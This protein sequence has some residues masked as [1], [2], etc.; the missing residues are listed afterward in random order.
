MKWGAVLRSKDYGKTWSRLKPECGCELDDIFMNDVVKT[1]DGTYYVAAEFGR[2]FI[3]R[4]DG[5]NWEEIQSESQTV[6][7]QLMQ[8]MIM[9]LL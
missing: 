6:S 1:P 9:K 3:T 5:G 8:E 4:D 2:I 7:V